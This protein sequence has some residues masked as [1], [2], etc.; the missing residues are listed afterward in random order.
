[1]FQLHVAATWTMVGV[2]WLVQLVNYPLFAKFEES[3]SFHAAHRVHM[4]GISYVVGPAMFVESATAAMLLFFDHPASTE[5]IIGA[6]LV[7]LLWG[8]TAFV[9]VP[10]HNQ[11]EERFERAVALRLIASNWFRTG[12]WSARGALLLWVGV[13]GVA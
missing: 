8:S 6:V 5:F 7:A 4:R 13:R 2:I 9:Q 3:E 11:L 12:V 10:Q 1:M